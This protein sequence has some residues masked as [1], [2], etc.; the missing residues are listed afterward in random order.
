[1][2]SNFILKLIT[3]PPSKSNFI[4]SKTLDGRTIKVFTAMND[5]LNP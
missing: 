2:P 4:P 3:F 5:E 1:M